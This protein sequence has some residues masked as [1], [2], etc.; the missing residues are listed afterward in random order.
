MAQGF[1]QNSEYVCVGTPEEN[2]LETYFVMLSCFNFDRAKDQCE[3][4]RDIK[5]AGGGGV[6]WCD[7]MNL[8]SRLSTAETSYF[9][10]QFNGR[11]FFKKQLSVV[12]DGLLHE[13]KKVHEV[14]HHRRGGTDF[15]W[16]R[17]LAELLTS[18]MEFVA[19]R[20]DMIGFYQILNTLHSCPGDCIRS[21]QTLRDIRERHSECFQ[22]VFLKPLKQSFWS[23]VEVLSL[24][25]KAQ[26]S[27]SDWQYLPSLISLQS[28]QTK[29][30]LWHGL[31]PPGLN[32]QTTSPRSMRSSSNA[33]SCLSSYPPLYKWLC[34]FH[35]VLMA[36][37]TTYFYKNLHSGGFLNDS[38]IISHKFQDDFL[39]LFSVLLK[40]APPNSCVCLVFDSNGL[41]GYKG[42]QYETPSAESPSLSGLNSYPI[43]MSIPQDYEFLS[44]RANIVSMI[45][46]QKSASNTT[47]IIST[48]LDTKLS[49]TYHLAQIEERVTMVTIVTT[50]RGK[51]YEVLIK[52]LTDVVSQLRL[53]HLVQA[54]SVASSKRE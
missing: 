1:L 54:L 18:V 5:S 15:S 2:V 31:H 20:R 44:H 17:K 8:L 21:N 10:M 35:N 9:S 33:S 36:K 46:N 26:I 49:C 12:Y 11:S 22:H 38:K 24:L 43:M 34:T 6:T 27:L 16:E 51:G 28:A 4:E 14:Y 42:P 45:M 53:Q 50:M 13:F 37:F 47:S 30:S 39:N 32:T 40:Q 25:L 3:R 19:A 41:A 7:F 29:L 23:E 52:K 48:Q